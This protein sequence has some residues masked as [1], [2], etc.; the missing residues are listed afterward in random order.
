MAENTTVGHTPESIAAL[1][2]DDSWVGELDGYF[3]APGE[4]D[5]LI[6]IIGSV[7]LQVDDDDYS[8][9]SRVLYKDGE[10]FGVLIFGWGSCSGCDAL[11]SCGSWKEVADI[12]NEMQRDTKWFDSAADALAYFETHDWAGDYSWHAEET[13]QF[14]EQASALFKASPRAGEGV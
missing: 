1:W 3:R 10:R 14:V 9:D 7:A 5:P 2:A 4:Y 11:Q 12:A 13:R 8:G 6:K